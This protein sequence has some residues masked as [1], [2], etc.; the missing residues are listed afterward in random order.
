MTAI[1]MDPSVFVDRRNYQ[2]GSEAP[3][4]ERR[5]FTNSHEGLSPEAKELAVAI[6]RY[7]LAHRRRFI[8]Y[9]EMLGVLKS[10]GYCKDAAAR[11]G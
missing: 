2:L 6:D 4:R 10:I 9:E 1:E 5:Q 7:K 8:T 11:A 3:G